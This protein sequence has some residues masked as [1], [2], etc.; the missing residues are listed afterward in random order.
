M[1]AEPGV[2]M[3]RLIAPRVGIPIHYDD[4]DVFKSSLADFQAEAAKAGLTERSHYINRG[5]SYGFSLGQQT[6]AAT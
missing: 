5:E 2:D 1:D 4:Y 3:L 6:E